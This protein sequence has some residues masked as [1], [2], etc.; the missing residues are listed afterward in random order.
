MK[1]KIQQIRKLLNHKKYLGY[2][3][4]YISTLEINISETPRSIIIHIETMENN[5]LYSIFFHHDDYF[6]ISKKQITGYFEPSTH[7]QID[8]LENYL[9]N[10]NIKN[11]DV[12]LNNII[13]LLI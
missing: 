4:L 12:F 11:I 1:E 8:E 2:Y 13:I 7:I 9:Q 5:L 10:Q 6:T 3:T